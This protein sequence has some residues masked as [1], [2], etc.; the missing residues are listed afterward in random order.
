MPQICC[1]VI[2]IL[3]SFSFLKNLIQCQQ[4]VGYLRSLIFSCHSLSLIFHFCSV[5]LPLDLLLK[6]FPFLNTFFKNVFHLLSHNCFFILKEIVYIMA[7]YLFYPSNLL[8]VLDCYPSWD[9]F[10]V[11]LLVDKILNSSRNLLCVLYT[12]VVLKIIHPY[13]INN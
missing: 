8:I 9:I 1:L 4:N 5:L 2:E 12:G 3:V 11:V 13:F 7:S 6:L 10:I